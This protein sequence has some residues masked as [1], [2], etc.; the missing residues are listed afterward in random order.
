MNN[1]VE[2]SLQP[3]KKG[4]KKATLPYWRVLDIKGGYV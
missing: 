2:T 4:L 1:C 3:H